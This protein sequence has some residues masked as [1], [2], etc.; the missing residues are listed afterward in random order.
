LPEVVQA[1]TKTGGWAPWNDRLFDAFPVSPLWVGAG[2]AVALLGLL[3]AIMFPLGRLDELA[4][5]GTGFWASRDARATVWVVLLVAFLP[6]ARRYLFLGARRDFED[7]RPLLT[8]E[9]GTS[10]PER[11]RLPAL[12]PRTHRV[13]AGMGL[14]V[15]PLTALVVDR[16]PSIYLQAEYWRPEAVWT[17]ALGCTAGW[18]LGGFIYAILG[19]S[20][21]FSGLARR[22]HPIDLLDLRPLEPF[23]RQGLRSV[24]LMVIAL[25][26]S[27][28]NATDRAFAAQILGVAAVVV[29]AGTL[30]FLLPAR[31]VR[32]RIR[33]AKQAE[34][35][36]LNAAIRGDPSML[37]GSLI[38]ARAEEVDLADLMAYR[39]YVESVREWPFDTPTLVRFV[40]YLAIPL[41]SW[42][43]G[44]L[45]ERLLGAALD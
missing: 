44:A 33:E 2:I 11:Q 14:L 6:T 43:G 26:L 32:A 12:D 21:R 28:M 16:D 34:L 45:V 8:Q 35:E 10:G 37:S 27:A 25:S 15:M 3:L 39:T 13:A 41:G 40:L 24:L 30:A 42:L 4:A 9:P 18:N 7:L 1:D 5:L 22:I 19:Y 38:A 23:G 20:R 17:W 36:R 31:G 29:V